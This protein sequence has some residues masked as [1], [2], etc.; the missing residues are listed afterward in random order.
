[1]A[2]VLT[3]R[4]GDVIFIGDD[5]EVCLADISRDGTQASLAFTAP[6]DVEIDRS[7]IRDRKNAER[8]LK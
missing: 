3:S 2:L 1:M 8:K 4:I 5:I 7:K 6:R